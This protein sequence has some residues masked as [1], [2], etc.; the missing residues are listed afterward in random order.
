MSVNDLIIPKRNLD[1]ATLL[2]LLKTQHAAKQDVV[3]PADSITSIWGKIVVPGGFQIM[4]ENGVT[5]GPLVLES[6]DTFD[7]GLC[8]KFRLGRKHLR[9]IRDNAAA[10]AFDPE[11]DGASYRGSWTAL[12][13]E[14]INRFVKADTRKMLVRSY[15]DKTTGI[16]VGRWLGSDSYGIIDNFD[17]I[18]SAME[19][20]NTS[21]LTTE[22]KATLSERKMTVH[23][24]CPEITALAPELLKGYRTPFEDS[25]YG[26]TGLRDATGN[27]PIVQAGFKLDNSETGGSRFVLT[28][29]ITVRVCTNGMVIN[30][31]KIA[32]THLGAKLDEGVIQWSDDTRR[33]NIELVKTTTRD[34]VTAFL[35]PGYLADT[36]A[37]LEE[38]AGKPLDSPN[39]TIEVVGK[40]LGF[41]ESEQ[42]LILSMFVKGGQSTTGGIMQAVT[43][44]AQLIDNPDRSEEV[45]SLGVEAMEAAYALA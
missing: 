34:V 39:K 6:T 37:K 31:A 3:V 26:Q 43:A 38:K 15:V 14:T 10:E 12:L 24:T 35:T 16:G 21:G 7:G 41:T 5:S 11:S 28:P 36:I 4:D 23:V 9:E 2:E 17:V 45:G 30:A 33:A 25:G 19:A 29:E 8:D 40:S 20:I 22:A 44:A 27:L 18:M 42:D 32:K 13:D 1:P